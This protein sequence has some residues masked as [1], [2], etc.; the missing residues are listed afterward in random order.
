MVEVLGNLPSDGA[1]RVEVAELRGKLA[2]L[3][4]TG[5]PRDPSGLDEL[6]IALREV[7]TTACW[8]PP[9]TARTGA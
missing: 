7:V 1:L 5:L 8:T 6:S 2:Q 9:T 4:H 3:L